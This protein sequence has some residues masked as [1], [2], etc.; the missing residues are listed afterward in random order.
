MHTCIYVDYMGSLLYVS[1]NWY[2]VVTLYLLTAYNERLD[3]FLE[4]D[5]LS[6]RFTYSKKKCSYLALPRVLLQLLRA[7]IDLSPQQQR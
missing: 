5:V 7:R 4:M 6:A 1:G 2:Q 3:M